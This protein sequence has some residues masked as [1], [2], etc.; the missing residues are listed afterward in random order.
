MSETKTKKKSLLFFWAVTAGE[1]GFVLMYKFGMD[2][3]NYILT[4]IAGFST[5]MAANIVMILGILSMIVAPTFGA[6]M[7]KTEWK[8]GH[9]Y[10]TW[11]F[12]LPPIVACLYMAMAYSLKV[13]AP[14][15]LIVIL[16]L[17]ANVSADSL[18]FDLNKCTFASIADTPEERTLA[19]TVSNWNKSI[20]QLIALVLGSSVIL[21]FSVSGSKWDGTGLFYGITIY[22]W[23]GVILFYTAAFTFRKYIEDAGKLKVKAH[24]KTPLLEVLKLALSNKVLLVVLVTIIFTNCRGNLAN[25]I[26]SYYFLYVIGD[27]SKYSTYALY[28]QIATIVGV[29]LIPAIKRWLIKESKWIFVAAV[30]LNAFSHF[31]VLFLPRTYTM[32]V[33]TNIIGNATYAIKGAFELL[34]L[35]NAVDVVRY[36]MFKNNINSVVPQ[37]VTM[38]M[39]SM[40]LGICKIICGYIRNGCLSAIGYHSGV[41][42]SPALADGFVK[43]YALMPGI[44]MLA[45]AIIFAIFYHTTDQQ[46]REMKAEIEAA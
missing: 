14:S 15:I 28:V 35:A 29:M 43:L 4:E 11:M 25:Q 37:G 12:I 41:E 33:L 44:G 26:Q 8:K 6:I 1:M 19:T 36:K 22:G 9:K 20:G 30:A 27:A 39:F 34:L 45:G 42:A 18:L 32:F 5:K 13:G 7:D 23:I 10:S 46:L 40:G 31:A 17:M 16:I 21:H 3:Q 24:E 2:F 38:A